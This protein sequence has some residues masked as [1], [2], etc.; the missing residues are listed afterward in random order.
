MKAFSRSMAIFAAI[1]AALS[2]ANTSPA[3]LSVKT[4]ID[5]TR[6]EFQYVSRGK[7]QNSPNRKAAGRHM[8]A[9]RK[10]RKIRNIRKAK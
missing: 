3:A 8:Q 2:Q 4:T 10:A 5:W 6:P 9:V 1:H 7:G